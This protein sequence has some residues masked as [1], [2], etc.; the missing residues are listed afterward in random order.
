MRKIC[1]DMISYE[2]KKCPVVDRDVC[3]CGIRRTR[4]N[5]CQKTRGGGGLEKEAYIPFVQ[6]RPK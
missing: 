5:G 6:E 3:I 4:L 1:I 2:G